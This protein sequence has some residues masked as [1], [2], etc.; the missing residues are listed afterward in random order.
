MSGIGGID[1]SVLLGFYQSQL[2]T[3]PS[4]IAAAS[5]QQQ[6]FAASQK[7]GATASDNPPWNTPNPNNAA[8]DAKVLGTTNFLDTSKVPLSPGATTDSKMEQDNQKLFSLYSAVNT[9]A[10]LAKMAQSGTATSGQLAGL[11]DRFQTGLAQVQQ[12]LDTTSF[13]KFNLQSAK[14]SDTVTSTAKIA[15]GSFSYATK[16]LV[17]NANLN[18]ALPG[19]SAS[20]SF[21]IGIKKGGVTTN[22]QI[23][24]SQVPGA[25][26]LSNIVSYINGQLSAAG[27]STR[28]QKTQTGGT[29]TS[30]TNATYGLQITPGGVEQ[31]SLSAASSPSLYLAGSSGLATETK[32]T[33]NTVTSA[34]TT[35]A[36]D[37]SA[38]L[39][40]LSGL[41]G[42]PSAAFSVNQKATNGI[43]S[44]QATAVDAS[45]NIYVIGTA[46]G[47]FGSQLNQGTQDVYLTKYDSAGNVVWQ[48]L[49][50]SGGS[51][52]GYGLALDPSGGVV[53]TGASTADL[54]TTSVADGNN[55]A[56]VARCDTNGAQTWIK[57]IQTLA[58]NQANAVS[59]DA[60]GNVTIGGSVSGG[61]VGAGQTGQ[62][63]ADAFLA[64][65]DSK[66]K[67]LAENQ[68]GTSGNDS[69][70]ATATAADGSLY[71]ASVQNGHAIL[72]K[73]ANGDITAAPAWT[74]DL[75]DLQAGG[76]IGGL[77]VAN[78]TVYVSGATSN[79]NLTAG[80]G[81]SIAA[82]ASG[83]IDAFVFSATDNGA[84]VTS[85]TVS[86]IGTAGTD[87]GKAVTVA[88][89]GTVYLTGSTTG[90]FAGAQRSVQNVNNAFAAALNSNG[91]IKWTQQYG[92]ADGT[93]TGAGLA[94]DP[95]GSSVLDALGLPRGAI[96][97]NQSV[98]LTTQ[99]TL[100]AGD[101]FKIE[102]Q[103]TAART[104]TITIDQGE[105]FDSL[106]TK[107]NA[108]LGGIGKASV[109]YTG[110]GENL[111]IQ[112]NAGKTINLVAGPGDFD[113]LSRLGIS[114]GVLTAP[115]KGSAST[116]TTT[117][118]GVTP[119]YGLGLTGGITGPLDIS[120]KMGAD[121]ARSTLLQVLSSIQSTYQTTNAPPPAHATPG[122]HS[123]SANAATTSQLANYSLALNLMN[124]DPSNAVANIQAI[125]ANGGQ[126]SD[127]G[128]SGLLSALGGL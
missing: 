111:K 5:A 19:L 116:T 36:P 109:N 4:S 92:G 75:G 37:Q 50:G 51:A 128:L 23:D 85:N 1:P 79:G 63:K 90:T 83:G 13:N 110:G 55:D 18:N 64:K 91:T 117:Q 84:S 17:T 42:T 59:V 96:S 26:N 2:I 104:A 31:V 53:V 67:L 22:V 9:L 35:T 77:T 68:F 120:S 24:L 61:V 76:S 65:F 125:V 16:Q 40:K 103:G 122:N 6:Q 81:A 3:S 66:G 69:V 70:A 7:K 27:F 112:V 115:A 93:S 29:A 28:F 8:Q 39:T 124:N 105:T 97:L 108:Q 58:N 10:Y 52:N 123:G 44:A 20:D 14:P 106:V 114:P 127:G 107:I 99:T 78:G 73:Y 74:Q 100:R 118:A 33:T 41:N 47:D 95:Q 48:N 89:D 12:Y 88:A 62:G 57:Q 87:S 121:M 56:F 98:D 32:T 82:A 54:T 102:I 15:F 49:L 60:S 71:V 45:G 43:T 25:L 86:Y 94:I 38:R 80:G 30:N 72:A 101:S 46:T 21:T 11:N 126:S 119:T 113:A 34:V